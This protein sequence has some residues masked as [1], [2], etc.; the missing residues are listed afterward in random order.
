MVLGF[1]LGKEMIFRVDRVSNLNDKHKRY[2]KTHSPRRDFP[3]VRQSGLS[4]TLLGYSKE[5][6][7]QFPG[8]SSS[9]QFR[10]VHRQ[11]SDERDSLEETGTW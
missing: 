5:Y 2:R 8:D 11:K 1:L 3:L 7:V 9:L 6:K 10:A 4:Q